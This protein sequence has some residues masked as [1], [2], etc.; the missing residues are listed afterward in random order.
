[1]NTSPEQQQ[2]R[3]PGAGPSS[4]FKRSAILINDRANENDKKILL[5]TRLVILPC[6][7]IL[8]H[9]FFFQVHQEDT[10]CYKCRTNG[11]DKSLST[12]FL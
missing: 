5:K 1:M 6:L 2:G 10:V 9:A 7:K 8:F 4:F 3:H 11:M 12:T